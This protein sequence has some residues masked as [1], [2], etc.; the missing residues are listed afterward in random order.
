MTD[1]TLDYAAYDGSLLS[2]ELFSQNTTLW[3]NDFGQ[4]QSGSFSDDNDRLTVGETFQLNGHEVEMMGSG[5]VQPGID[6]FGVVVP[7]GQSKDV[8]V[9]SDTSSGQHYFLYPDGPPN[10]LGSVALVSDVQPV[11]YDFRTSG[12]LCFVRGTRLLTPRG[13]RRVESLC[14]GDTLLDRD[15][16]EVPALKVF[17]TTLTLG[18]GTREALAPVEIA[19]HAYGHGCPLRPVRLSPQHR[20]VIAGPQLELYMGVEEALAPARALVNGGTIRRATELDEVAYYHVLCPAHTILVAEGLEAESLLLGD[21]TLGRLPAEEIREAL[22]LFPD[23]AEGFPRAARQP[24]LPLL[25]RR[26][27]E[28]ILLAERQDFAPQHHAA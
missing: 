4:P 27:A 8:I 21:I 15:G 14:A 26:E 11:G 28:L 23:A 17:S 2:T 5:T 7:L 16:R 10:Q 25:S 1:Y 3:L 20:L 19:A 13:Y 6:A 12:P 24:C 9:A 18:P 22:D